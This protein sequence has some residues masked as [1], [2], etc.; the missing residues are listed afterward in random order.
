MEAKELRI[1]NLVYDYKEDVYLIEGIDLHLTNL[2]D[3][4]IKPIPLTEEWLLKFYLKDEGIEKFNSPFYSYRSEFP[5]GTSYLMP[6]YCDLVIENDR[7]YYVIGKGG[8]EVFY[9]EIKYVHQLQNL[10]F[11]LTNNEL[12]CN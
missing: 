1:G 3:V 2:H 6:D 5:K 9:K 11:A 10:Y 8:E 12:S 7:Y 4:K